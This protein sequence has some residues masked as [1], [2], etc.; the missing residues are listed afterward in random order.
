MLAASAPAALLFALLPAAGPVPLAPAPDHHAAGE[1]PEG[2]VTEGTFA[3]SE[4][5]PGTARQ[6][7]VYVPAQ[8]DGKA[9]AALMVFQDGHNFTKGDGPFDVPGKF[10]RLIAGGAMPVTIAVMVDPGYSAAQM[11]NELGGEPPAGRGW[12]AKVNGKRIKPGNRS[13]EYDTVT[14]AYARYLNEE[15]L[16]VALEGLNVTDAPE[17]RAICGNSS[18]GIAAFSVAWFTAGEPG[19]FNKVISH[20]GSFTGIRGG[21]GEGVPGG[22]EYPVMIRK[23]DPKPIRVALQDG[24]NDLSNAHGDWW[25]ANQQMASALKYKGYDYKTWWDEGGHGSRFAA[26]TFEE[27]LRW[28]WRDWREAAG[29]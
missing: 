26:P 8:Y 9:P 27:R 28:L 4:I 13:I 25:L 21:R 15:L 23:N 18:G 1:V 2:K 24:S 7:S 19:G 29:E 17:M 11:K 16:P 3:Q 12:E 10:D 5:Y 20:I 6:Y 14:D 22:H